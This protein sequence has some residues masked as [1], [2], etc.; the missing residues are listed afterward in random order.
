MND[1]LESQIEQLRGIFTR[2]QEEIQAK[3]KQV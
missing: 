1:K 2:M 3:D